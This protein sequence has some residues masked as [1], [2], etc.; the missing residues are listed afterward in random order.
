MHLGPRVRRVIQ[1]YDL[2]DWTC[3]G[4]LFV[5]FLVVEIWASPF[6][7]PFSWRDPA[8]SL[9]GRPNTFP[10]WT[11]PVT[12][13]FTFGFFSIFPMFGVQL[14]RSVTNQSIT[15]D[16]MDEVHTG[17]GQP[18][19][20]PHE[21]QSSHSANSGLFKY[22]RGTA[23]TNGPIYPWVKSMAT[24]VVLELFTVGAAK[25]YA[26]RLRPDFLSRMA[27]A[28][29]TSDTQTVNPMEDPEY[30]C[31]LTQKTY[32][33]QDGRQS[34]PSGHSGVFF[35]TFTML[36]LFFF[37]HLRPFACQGSVA[38]LFLAL[39]VLFVPFL[40]SISRTRDHKHNYSDILTGSLIGMACAFLGYG[41]CF[42]TAGGPVSVVLSRSEQD[43]E[44]LRQ[45]Q[46][47]CPS[48]SRGNSMK[49]R[50]GPR[51]LPS[52]VTD[53][54]S[55]SNNNDLSA[56]NEVVVRIR[57]DEVGSPR[58]ELVT[59]YELNENNKNAVPWL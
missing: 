59:E 19:V 53:Y 36:S 22:K 13:L 41:V 17:D 49:C 10:N 54:G 9:P 46:P 5:V 47:P 42:R 6:C 52:A 39:S 45:Y 26:G 29:Y 34:F 1:Q 21:V 25:K 33:L 23:V 58:G 14:L 27:A 50:K 48:V 44:Y 16:A 57:E 37:A 2:V 55:G 18:P 15:L 24:A 30:Y 43:V 11:L 8:I 3:I 4:F 20:V 38:R 32:K 7:R 56:E 12:I 40:C 28:G 35:V 31:R 51:D